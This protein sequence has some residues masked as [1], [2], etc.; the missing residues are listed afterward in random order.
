MSVR[1]T[2]SDVACTIG[3]TVVVSFA[4]YYLVRG[5]CCIDNH[6]RTKLRHCRT[7]KKWRTWGKW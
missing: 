4:V 3:T 1:E 7:E 5:V 6:I 2:I